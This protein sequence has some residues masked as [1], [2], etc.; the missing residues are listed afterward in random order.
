MKQL[1]KLLSLSMVCAL[2]LSLLTVGSLPVAADEVI[3]VACVGDSITAGASLYNYPM[4]LQDMLG[5]GYE[6]KNFGLGGAAVRHKEESGGGYFWYDSTQYQGSLQY[7]ADVVFVMMGTNDVG[8]NV[9]SLRNYFKEDYYTY[10]VKPYLDK[11]AKVIL[12]TSPFAYEYPMNDANRINTV[13]RDYQLELAEEKD[14]PLIDMNTATSGMRE[15]FPDGLHGNQSGYMVIATTIYKEYFGG[16]VATVDVTTTPGAL[17]SI[18]RV[19]IKA[20][21]ETGVASLPVLP[22]THEL[23]VTL[24]G[25]KTAKGTINVPSGHSG[26]EVALTEG[27]KNLAIGATATASSASGD[28]TADKAIDGNDGSTRW[29]SEWASPQWI[30]VDLGATKKVGAIRIVWEP[31]FASGYDIMASTNGTDFT[32]VSTVTGGDGA[33][34]EVVFDPVD[35]QYIKVVCNE[36]GSQWS[37]SMYELMIVE[38]VEGELTANLGEVV[39]TIIPD[40]VRVPWLWIGVGVGVL[41][42]LAVALILILRV[43]GKKK[44]TAPS[45]E[46][47]DTASD[48]G[49]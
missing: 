17:V 36:K 37:Y 47:V 18:G 24:D 12:L 26:C 10:L 32:T 5:D 43:A 45:A 49:Q 27:G 11:G 29:E 30:Q 16:D 40:P 4:Y 3:H 14:L 33:V 15:C 44:K 8:S 28:K 9:I 48:A 42:L 34:D 41:A 46:G 39:P 7:D 21:A 31:A 13:I 2:V 25:Y 6:V 23:A 22:G 20:N 19:G 1:C 38:A 35:A